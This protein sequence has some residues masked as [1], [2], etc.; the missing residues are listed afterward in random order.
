MI[1]WFRSRVV[2]RPAYPVLPKDHVVYAFGDL[3]GRSDLLDR[4]LATIDRTEAARRRRVTEVYLGD[5]VDRGP[6]SAGVVDR[7][8]LRAE[9]HD[10]VMLRGNHEQLFRDAMDGEIGLDDWRRVGGLATLAS[11][12]GDLPYLAGLADRPFA[13]ALE[14][15]VPPAHRAFLERLVDRHRIGGYFFAHAGIRPGVALDAQS[16]EDLHWIREPF[17]GDDRDFGA[18]VVHGH[19]PILAP[20]FRANRICID[21]GAY[22]TDRLTCLRIDDRGVDVVAV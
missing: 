7:L 19:T 15:M 12:G 2:V 3:H 16:R 20:E 10:T 4:A 1:D 9:F 13:A 14:A 17:L 22:A 5:Y 8:I 21:T 11:Y 6:D 18:V